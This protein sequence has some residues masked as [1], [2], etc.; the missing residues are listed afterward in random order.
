[1]SELRINNITDT[2]GSSGPIIAGV[3]TVTSTSHM[4]MPSGP[5][6]MRGGRGRGFILGGN[7][8]PAGTTNSIEFLTIA[9]TGN[10]QDFGDL[11]V[12][13]MQTQGLSNSTRGVCAGGLGGDNNDKTTID[14]A[15]L[16]SSGGTNDFGDLSNA[17]RT[18]VGAGQASNNTIG[19]I[20]G[21]YDNSDISPSRNINTVEFIIIDTTGDASEFGDMTHLT[22]DQGVASS[23]T[24]AV[25]C[26]GYNEPT[27]IGYTDYGSMSRMQYM[28]FAT[29]GNSENFGQLSHR[30]FGVLAT[31]S[32]TRGVIAGGSGVEP[33]FPNTNIIEFITIATESN[34]TDFGD[35]TVAR[36]DGF[37]TSNSIRGI[38]AGGYNPTFQNV[39][40]FVTIASTGNASDFGDLLTLRRTGASWGDSHGGLGD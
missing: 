25:F 14:Y 36:R 23:T 19:I 17:R 29:K 2:A 8:S 13:R 6:E 22:R 9:T 40:D 5:T 4:V 33:S 18:F 38:F 16:S 7:T 21:G 31:S 1:M 20:A 35:L 12:S 11:S 10:G 24:R 30:S 39:I 32:A 37:S 27:N 26:G 34:T 3:S 28:T 15:I